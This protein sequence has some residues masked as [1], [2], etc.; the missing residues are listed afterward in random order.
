MKL[1]RRQL[2]SLIENTIISEEKG[3]LGTTYDYWAKKTLS[4]AGDDVIGLAKDVAIPDP[5]ARKYNAYRREIFDQAEEEV[6]ESI[7]SMIV[8]NIESSFA[9]IDMIR[10]L[11]PEYKHE[12]TLEIAKAANKYLHDM[13]SDVTAI[14]S[15]VAEYAKK[16]ITRY[17][18]AKLENK[19]PPMPDSFE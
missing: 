18:R 1:T 8:D 16:I 6:K 9:S 19:F 7:K 17:L 13:G 5:V 10:L 4:G 11:P 15:E 3:I 2:R 12:Y 14:S